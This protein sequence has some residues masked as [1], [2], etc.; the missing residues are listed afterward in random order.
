M[1]GRVRLLTGADGPQE[2]DAD[3]LNLMRGRHQLCARFR[4]TYHACAWRRPAEAAIA[5]RAHTRKTNLAHDLNAG[6]SS[7]MMVKCILTVELLCNGVRIAEHA[8]RASFHTSAGV[9]VRLAG[10]P[11]AT[12]HT[13]AD[14]RR[15]ELRESPTGARQLCLFDGRGEMIAMLPWYAVVGLS[16]MAADSSGPGVK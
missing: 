10:A 12:W 11:D 3:T 9:R 8:R 1:S 16:D 2:D 14:A 5:G 13:F 15:V 6:R 7:A 4:E